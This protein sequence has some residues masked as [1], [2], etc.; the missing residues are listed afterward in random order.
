MLLQV[1]P[2]GDGFDVRWLCG[3]IARARIFVPTAAVMTVWK[4]AIV[5]V[6]MILSCKR[7]WF[8]AKWLEGV[9]KKH[10]FPG[11]SF[12]VIDRLTS[13]RC[14]A[15]ATPWS[16]SGQWKIE[17]KWERLMGGRADL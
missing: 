4:L 9:G 15:I 3:E 13:E 8:V 1:A 6:E 17:T 2:A 14:P 16:C 10:V 7:R 5:V 11:C 12:P